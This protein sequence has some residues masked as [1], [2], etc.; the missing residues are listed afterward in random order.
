MGAKFTKQQAEKL[1]IV[2]NRVKLRPTKA[3]I[4]TRLELEKLQER[5]KKSSPPPITP[6]KKCSKYG[7]KKTTIGG[8]IF[9][10]KKEALR[11]V[12]LKEMENKGE[13][14]D[15]QLQVKYCFV[16][17]GV[18]IASYVADFA[19][20]KKDGQSVVEDVK[21]FKT[22]IYRLKKKMMR[23]FFGISIMET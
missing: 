18:K 22:N 7:N 23:A 10:S 20:L 14:K 4:K 13:I 17:N 3:E 8:K 1:N 5:V 11:Y 21:G 19:Y 15:L 12:Q 2:E 16:Y 6:I 9:D